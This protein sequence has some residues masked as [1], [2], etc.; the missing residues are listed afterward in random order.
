MVPLVQPLHPCALT[1]VPLEEVHRATTPVKILISGN[2]QEEMV[3]LVMRFPHV[4]LVL[5]RPWMRKHNPQVDWSRGLITGWSPGCHTSCLQSAAEPLL[6]P[7]RGPITPP[8]LSLVPIEYHDLGE[9]F[10]KSHATSLPPNHSYDC[11]IDLLSGTSPPRG[12]LFSLSAPEC[13]AMEK[14]IG[15]SLVA[16]LIRPSS[17]PAGFFFL[18]KKDGSLHQCIDYRGLN[19]I[20]V[21]NRYP[22]PLISSAFAMLQNARYFTKLDLRNTYHLVRIREG[23]EWKTAFNTPRGDYEYCVMP[24]GLTNVPAVFQAL[25]NDVLHDVINHNVFVYLDDI[26]VFSE[27]LEEHVAHFRLILQHLLENHLFA[28]AEKSKFHRSTV[29]FLG[30]VVSRGKLEMDPAKTKAVVA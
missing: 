12:R 22:I 29:Q 14:Y 30:F 3:L 21:K 18:G 24:F 10:N 15:E 5:G 1:G 28:K 17:S 2:H 8:D 13:L 4:P 25:V 6:S 27:S 19:E 26:L 7:Q 23:D 11:A 16:G 20:T 9:V